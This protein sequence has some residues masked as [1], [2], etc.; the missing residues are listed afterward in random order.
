MIT[1]QLN[2]DVDL[3]GVEIIEKDQKLIQQAR[4]ETEKQA[5]SMLQRGLE[6]QN[7]SQVSFSFLSFCRIVITWHDLIGRHSTAGFSQ[8]GNLTTD[9]RV[10]SRKCKRNTS[11]GSKTGSQYRA[12]IES[13]I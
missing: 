8:F 9:C 11:Q 7:Q 3:S 13:F 4:I 5:K 10:C 6:S 1:D 12:V 2:K